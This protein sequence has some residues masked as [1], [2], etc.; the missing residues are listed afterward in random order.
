M[1]RQVIQKAVFTALQRVH[2]PISV[3]ELMEQLRTDD[4]AFRDVPDFDIRSAVLALTANGT[5]QSTSTN[6]V[7]VRPV[8]A[9][10]ARG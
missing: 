7:E 3:R 8:A 2:H 5:V 4:P 6:Q 10:V 9:A 1:S